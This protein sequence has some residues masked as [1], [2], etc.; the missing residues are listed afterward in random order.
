MF[1]FFGQSRYI[2]DGSAK[3]HA[4]G[5]GGKKSEEPRVPRTEPVS[6]GVMSVKVGRGSGVQ[7][8]MGVY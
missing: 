3:E 4:W 8:P 7:S 1:E 2:S 5:E 6:H